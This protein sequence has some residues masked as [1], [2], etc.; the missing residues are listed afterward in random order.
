MQGTVCELI[1]HIVLYVCF[2]F[3]ETKPISLFPTTK[4]SVNV[5][6]VLVGFSTC[7]KVANHC[8]TQLISS[9]KA[10]FETSF[11]WAQDPI[12]STTL[13]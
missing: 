6:M 11:K 7:N 12:Y 9:L 13:L 5:Y 3:E 10:S 2:E 8:P 1:Q 4:G